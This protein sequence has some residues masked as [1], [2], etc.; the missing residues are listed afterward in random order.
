MRGYPERLKIEEFAGIKGM[1][2]EL[3]HCY[4]GILRR[5]QNG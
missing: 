3:R 4:E 1:Y 5:D 2:R